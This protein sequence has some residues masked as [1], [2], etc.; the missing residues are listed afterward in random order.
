MTSQQGNVT[1]RATILL[2]RTFP[3]VDLGVPVHYGLGVADPHNLAG[4]KKNL[5]TVGEVAV[6]NTTTVNVTISVPLSMNQT[7]SILEI[8]AL[9]LAS[10]GDVGSASSDMT[11]VLLERSGNGQLRVVRTVEP[12]DYW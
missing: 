8:E 2:S 3:E 11:Y 6:A 9:A 7:A 5:T 4:T 1:V 10:D 12:Q